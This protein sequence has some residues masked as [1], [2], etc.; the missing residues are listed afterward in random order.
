MTWKNT[1][2]RYGSLSITL[3]WL[4]VVLLIAVYTC[5][6]LRSHFDR[7]TAGRLLSGQFHYMFGLTI[8]ALVWL[9]L[10]A[11]GLGVT[12]RITP[13]PPRWQR[14]LAWLMHMALYALMIAMPVLGWLT[15]SGE[16]K[17]I[18]FWGLQM[19]PLMAPDKELA[20]QIE[21]WHIQIGEWGYWLI[22]LHTLAGLAHHY[23]K[24][25]DT[26]SRMLPRR[27]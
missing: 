14:R 1:L 5:T 10:L 23:L 26:L 3:H 21:D 12:P 16:G 18:P 11:R 2:A 22:G 15:L 7:G 27:R 19:P 9:R 6:E 4:M 17:A 13:A 8:F 24:R 20:A 25:D